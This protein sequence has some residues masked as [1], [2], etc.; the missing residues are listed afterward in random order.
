MNIFGFIGDHDSLINVLVL[1][2]KIYITKSWSVTAMVHGVTRDLTV[3]M[4]LSLVWSSLQHQLQENN[5][6]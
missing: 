3:P 4:N 2:L 1:L 6:A 5:G